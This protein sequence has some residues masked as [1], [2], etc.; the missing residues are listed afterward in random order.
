MIAMKILVPVKRVIDPY[1]KIRLSV[2]N[3]AIETE[4]VKMAMNPFDEIALEEAVR[5]KERGVATEIIVVSIGVTRCQETL[6]QALALGADRGILIESEQNFAP[7]AIAKLLHAVAQKQTVQLVLMGKQAI[8]DDCNQ[9]GQMLA[10][11]LNWPQVT[12]VSQLSIA[13]GT[14]TAERECDIGTQTLCCDLPAVV[15]ADLCL[16]TPRFAKLPDIMRAKNKPL[17]VLTAES[18]ALDLSSAMTQAC[19]ELTT[20]QRCSQM[21]Q[22]VA[23]LVDKLRADQLI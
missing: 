1:V 2:N 17:E 5:L 7:L 22:N 14:L 21:V 10:A 3:N 18:F 13:N 8:D 9:T 20:M 23:E 19:I 12:F 4:Q 11:L 6:R 16:N 15:T